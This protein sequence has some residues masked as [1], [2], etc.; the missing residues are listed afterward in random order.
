M[1]LLFSIGLEIFYF[2]LYYYN[3]FKLY[4]IILTFTKLALDFPL[5]ILIT[6][7]ITKHKISYIHIC[8][9]F[10]TLYNILLLI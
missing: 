3:H 1:Q 10:I 4:Y 2:C 9:Y 7:Y 6:L 5:L 8:L